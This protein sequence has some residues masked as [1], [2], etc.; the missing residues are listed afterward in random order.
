MGPRGIFP[1]FRSLF[2]LSRRVR[3]PIVG[4]RITS[5]VNTPHHHDAP[6]RP[7]L[8]FFRFLSGC[9]GSHAA[10]AQRRYHYTESLPTTAQ[11][12]LAK[13]VVP[14]LVAQ[15]SRNA[16]C[17]VGRGQQCSLT[18]RRETLSSLSFSHTNVSGS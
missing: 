2:S 16:L 3:Q 8:D 6:L 11:P 12:K 5:D 18:S 7:A 10:F 4:A 13:R 1:C 9:P 15:V 17:A 14:S